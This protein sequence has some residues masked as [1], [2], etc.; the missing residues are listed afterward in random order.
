MHR[1]AVIVSVL[2]VTGT[3]VTPQDIRGADDLPTQGD[4]EAALTAA[5]KVVPE[6]LMIDARLIERGG[7]LTYEILFMGADGELHT[8]QV[9]AA[10]SQIV[11]HFD[12][13]EPGALERDEDRRERPAPEGKRDDPH[14]SHG[15]GHDKGERRGGS[16]P[17]GDGPR[18]DG[19]RG[20]GN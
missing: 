14:P 16:G 4:F 19:P 7:S 11:N 18:G 6:S 2:L 13:D 10:R 17:Q 20:K 3:V 8:V 9:D 5:R 1:A 15:P 12:S